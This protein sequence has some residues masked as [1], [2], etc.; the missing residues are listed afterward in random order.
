MMKSKLSAI[1]LLAA[2]LVAAGYCVL[3]AQKQGGIHYPTANPPVYYL[4]SA[5]APSALKQGGPNVRICD[6]TDDHVQLQ[7]MIDLAEAAGAPAGEDAGWY[8]PTIV[9]SAGTF[10]IGATVDV[11]YD[12]SGAPNGNAGVTIRAEGRGAWLKWSGGTTVAA[13]LLR[14]CPGDAENAHHPTLKNLIFHGDDK[15]SGLYVNTPAYLASMGNLT[16][17]KC[18]GF[19]MYVAQAYQGR[20]HDLY[21]EDCDGGGGLVFQQPNGTHVHHVNMRSC[22]ATS[23]PRHRRYKY[24]NLA[25]STFQIFEYVETAGSAEVGLVLWQDSDELWV[26][27]EYSGGDNDFDDGDGIT[28]LTSGATADIDDD[29]GET[30]DLNAGI[31]F[32]GR[33]PVN[34]APKLSHLIIQGNSLE[35]DSSSTM[36]LILIRKCGQTVIEQ[37]Y[38]EGTTGSALQ[39]KQSDTYIEAHDSYSCTF[40]NLNFNPYGDTTAALTVA[41]AALVGDTI[42]TTDAFEDVLADDDYIY[43]WD[44]LGGLVDGEYRVALT[45]ADDD[46]FTITTTPGNDANFRISCST[47]SSANAAERYRPAIGIDL[48]NCD[49]SRIENV[50]ASGFRTALVQ[51]DSDSVLVSVHG[52]RDIRAV[53]GVITDETVWT[54]LPHPP[55]DVVDSGTGTKI[56]NHHVYDASIRDYTGNPDA[57]QVFEETDG[58]THKT[59]LV[60]LEKQMTIDGTGGVGWGTELIYTIPTGNGY[61]RIQGVVVDV[62]IDATT[63]YD[64]GT[65]IEDDAEGDF[66]VGRTGTVDATLEGT[67]I[68]HNGKTAI[69]ELGTGALDPGIGDLDG[70]PLAP[71]NFNAT[72]SS[73]EFHLNVIIDDADIAADTTVVGFTGTVTIHWIELG[74]N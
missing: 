57:V 8:G 44:G 17:H 50:G 70:G 55:Q 24:E 23:I 4:V 40:K 72:A 2:S 67:D 1:L 29:A 36:P 35:G 61:Y 69:L 73:V 26:Q 34:V 63:K 19:S 3:P 68:N 21:V 45:G 46:T 47:A 14:F 52:L 74:N 32:Y 54:N 18:K 49:S 15:A 9:L 31:L 27:M 53:S 11:G 13:W 71:A 42:T 66:S 38:T 37:L 25:V 12:G 33:T 56:T 51:I 41:A 7:E 48:Y 62:Q 20:F 30:Q 58:I 10:D 6:G 28:G 43:M 5:D 64:S 16:F 60:M 39:A 22:K 59:T 65:I